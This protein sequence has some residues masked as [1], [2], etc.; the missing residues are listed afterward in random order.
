[1]VELYNNTLFRTQLAPQLTDGSAERGAATDIARAAKNS[2]DS[3]EIVG[4]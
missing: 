3:H 4:V 1:M 2:Y